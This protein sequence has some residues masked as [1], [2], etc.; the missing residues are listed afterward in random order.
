[1]SPLRLPWLKLDQPDWFPPSTLALTQPNGLL[2]GGGDL[3]PARL[4]AAYRRGIF[5]WFSPGEPILWWTPDPRC[6]LPLD[7]ARP[8]TRMR[9]WLRRCD[10]RLSADQV[11]AEVMA[12]CAKPRN[13]Q[14]GTWIT[15]GMQ[16][17]YERLHQLGHA[18]SVEVRDPSGTLIGGIYGLSIGRMFFGE[19]MFSRVSQA[20]KVAVFALCQ[21]LRD[22]GFECLDGQVENAHLLS[23][24][25]SC[26]PRSDFERLLANAVSGP[27]L[28]PASW[29]LDSAAA[30][31]DA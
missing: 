8:S 10:W 1:M 26:M 19:S 14:R 2:C 3:Q 4:L 16:L 9:R 11:F 5:P 18:H 15:P 13:G 31:S 27:G 21:V 24:G 7:Q 25:F 28:W 30:L 12:E 17:A 23:L 6:V 20:S 29:P 22:C